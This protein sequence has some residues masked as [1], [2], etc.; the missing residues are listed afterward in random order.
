VRDKVNL[1][2]GVILHAERDGD[3]AA[4]DR[5]QGAVIIMNAA[6]RD[7][8]RCPTSRAFVHPVDP[9]IRR[10]WRRRNQEGS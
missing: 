4:C 7:H 9:A 6:R 10:Q 3:G 1:L 2:A 8:T 5:S